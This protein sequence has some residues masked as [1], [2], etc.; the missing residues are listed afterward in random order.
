[1]KANALVALSPLLQQ[2]GLCNLRLQ[3]HACI[4]LLWLMI[5]LMFHLPAELPVFRTS[6]HLHLVSFPF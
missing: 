2:H 5:F 3:E 1:M 6:L 4:I